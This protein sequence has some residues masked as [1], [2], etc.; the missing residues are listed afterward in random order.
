MGQNAPG[1]FSRAAP[2]VAQCTGSPQGLGRGP[3]VRRQPQQR[4]HSGVYNFLTSWRMRHR[5]DI[6][7]R[8]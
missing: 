5:V 1:D 7:L 4:F 6:I 3:P 2:E 8:M